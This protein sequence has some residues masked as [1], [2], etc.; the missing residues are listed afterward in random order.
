MNEVHRI[1]TARDVVGRR[2]WKIVSAGSKRGVREVIVL[3]EKPPSHRRYFVVF[4]DTG[5]RTIADAVFFD[6]QQAKNVYAR[7]V[8]DRIRRLEEVLASAKAEAA[9]L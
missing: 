7:R 1:T 4:V 9:L 5:H 6:E 8:Y 2:G 3:D